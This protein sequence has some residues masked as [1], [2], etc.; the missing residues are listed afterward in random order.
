MPE[1]IWNGVGLVVPDHWEP[2]GLERDSLLLESGARPVCE[3]KWNVVRGSFS[4]EKHLKRLAK[5]HK[6]ADVH[7]VELADTPEVWVEAVK[8]L[9]RSGL[10]LR[11]FIWRSDGHR[12]I[13]AALHNPGTGLAALVQFFIV[14]EADESVAAEVLASFRDHSGGKT[15]PWTLFGLAARVPAEFR[16]ETFSFKPGRYTV[17]YW[18]ARSARQDNRLPAGKGPGTRLTF[19]RFVPA[20]VLLKE[21][22]LETWVGDVLNE[23]PGSL[24]V[25]T[26]DNGLAWA[27]VVRT[28]LLR[29][30]LRRE[31]HAR[32]R[33][34]TT[35]RGN[36][37]LSVTT[38]GTVPMPEEIFKTIVRS[39]TLV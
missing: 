19:E 11:S 12:G 36:A 24:S 31:N 29:K 39:Y 14:E 7:G 30:L 15:V 37:I 8:R 32:G 2:A 23:P 28:S 20:S 22:D 35:E 34:W 6:D 25:T 17:S 3:L 1:I 9:T 16:L 38:D 21:S 27:G 18:R 26:T 13:G 33:V 4:F 10:R 5:G